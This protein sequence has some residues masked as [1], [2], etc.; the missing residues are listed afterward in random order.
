[1][2]NKD[3]PNRPSSNRKNISTPTWRPKSQFP[4]RRTVVPKGPGKEKISF[5]AWPGPRTDSVFL[6]RRS[7]F[8]QS[9][10]NEMLLN[11]ILAI[12]SQ[13]RG[14]RYLLQCSCPSSS[15]LEGSAR[16]LHHSYSIKYVPLSTRDQLNLVVL[17]SSC[18]SPSSHPRIAV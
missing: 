4:R 6:Y 18:L 16:I 3:R 8:F 13:L 12:Y 1:M 14:R 11:K 17:P 7:A 10:R 2:G 15:I 5:Q 9:V